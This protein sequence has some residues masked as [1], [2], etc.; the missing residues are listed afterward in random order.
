MDKAIIV[1]H[2]SCDDKLKDVTFTIQKGEFVGIIGAEDSGKE[3]LLDI[4]SGFSKPTSG[5]VS[6]LGYDP[7]LRN[8][9]FLKQIAFIDNNKRQL[10]QNLPAIDILEIT[11]TIYG[12]TNRDFHRNLS[13]LAQS[14]N[15]PYILDNIIY[16]PKILLINNLESNLDPIYE[17]NKNNES[18]SIFVTDKFD[19][20]VDFVR[21]VIILDKGQ[22]LFDG[23]IDEIISKF[24]KE[25]IIK[26]KLS[27]PIDKGQLT[28][29]GQLKKYVYPYI[30]LSSP[31][32]VISFTAAE[33]LQNLPVVSLNIEEPNIEEI[34]EKIKR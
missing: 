34:I 16:K 5:F 10:L 27:S 20:L 19:K 33:M 11:K 12:L 3:L 7:L 25:K 9:D 28:D 14:I 26:A 24:A 8:N 31:R 6:V 2:L 23:A 18:T 13:E 30:Y 29:L 15:D 32:S 21:R 1:D 22:I 17:F 4:I